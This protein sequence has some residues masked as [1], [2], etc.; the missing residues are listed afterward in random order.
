VRGRIVAVHYDCYGR[1][2]GFDVDTC[3]GLRRL[4]AR[5]KVLEVAVVRAAADGVKVTV[6]VCAPDRACGLTVH[7]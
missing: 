1:F 3:P 6:A 4:E 7:Y 5:G 2:V